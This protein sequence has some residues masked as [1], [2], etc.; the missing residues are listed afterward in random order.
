MV[1]AVVTDGT[2]AGAPLTFGP[3]EMCNNKFPDDFKLDST[4]VFL[5]CNEIDFYNKTF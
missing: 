3:S 4:G 1:L 5:T 2:A